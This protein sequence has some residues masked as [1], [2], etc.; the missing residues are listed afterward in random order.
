[1]GTPS[2][3]IAPIV[4]AVPLGTAL[5]LCRG[6]GVQDSSPSPPSPPPTPGSSKARS[7]TS[8]ASRSMARSSRRSAA[9]P[10]SPSP[11]KPANYTLKQ[12]PPGPYLVR[13][14][15]A[16]FLA[17]RST[18]VNVRPVGAQRFVVHAAPRGRGQRAAHYR[19]GGGAPSAPRPRTPPKTDERD[20]TELGWR[21]RHLKRGVLRDADTLAGIPAGRRLVHHRFVR[22]PRPRRRHVGARPPRRCS[23]T[24]RSAARSTC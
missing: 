24:C 12:L 11:T 17:A 14:H 6:A 13:A 20:E 2:R 19:S 3:L 10:R 22:V 21:L 9:P 5:D 16:G 1:M 18:M 4:H 15:L 8:S 7:P 23:P